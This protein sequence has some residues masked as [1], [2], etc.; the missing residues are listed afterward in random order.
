[1]SV[2]GRHSNADLNG[3]YI[4][5]LRSLPNMQRVQCGRQVIHIQSLRGTVDIAGLYTFM[6]GI[7]ILFKAEG[8]AISVT[9]RG[10]P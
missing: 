3:C 10:G 7:R 9:G 2:D 6:K 8:K 1:M 5:Y 4:R